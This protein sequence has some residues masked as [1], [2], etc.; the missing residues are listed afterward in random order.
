MR[1][2]SPDRVR[3]IS[4]APLQVLL[5]RKPV[6]VWCWNCWDRWNATSE[7]PSEPINVA[8]L[9]T[10]AVPRW[11]LTSNLGCLVGGTAAPS[12][13]PSLGLRSTVT[14]AQLVGPI[15]VSHRCATDCSA[16]E[17]KWPCSQ[18]GLSK[19]VPCELAPQPSL[20][21]VCLSTLCK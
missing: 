17:W 20:L 1:P 11:P 21:E 8:R 10:T 4:F 19:S 13:L 5:V 16:G 6:R 2:F 3:L 14:S 9:H 7:L 15:G 12:P 18:S